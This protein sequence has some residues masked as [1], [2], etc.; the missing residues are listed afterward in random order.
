MSEDER[1]VLEAAPE[2][3]PQQIGAEG[4]DRTAAERNRLVKM[5]LA[6]KTGRKVMVEATIARTGVAS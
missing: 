3:R 6:T 4:K 5:T 2:H 1:G